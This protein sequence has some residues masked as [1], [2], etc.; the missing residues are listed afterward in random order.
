MIGVFSRVYYFQNTT[1][2]IDDTKYN[3]P[4]LETI[5]PQKNSHNLD[6]VS[7]DKPISKSVYSSL[8][9]FTHF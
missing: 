8:F 2:R 5:I 6:W 1:Q 7:V 4:N 3:T 9:L